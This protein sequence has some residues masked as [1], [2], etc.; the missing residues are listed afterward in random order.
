MADQ[1]NL[2]KLALRGAIELAHDVKTHDQAK[3]QFE[4]L[5]PQLEAENPQL[6]ALV[7]QLWEEYVS[8]QR[9]AAFWKG[10]SDAEKQL[11]DRMTETNIQLQQ[12]YNRLMQEQ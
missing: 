3:A 5:Y 4:E 7:R 6:A 8:L 1:S 11:S 9:S 10:M 2:Y 12:N